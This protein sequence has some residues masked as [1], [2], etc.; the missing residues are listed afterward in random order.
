MRCDALLWSATDAGCCRG[1]ES[2]RARERERV[3][4][5]ER[6]RGSGRVRP[7]EALSSMCCEGTRYP[8]AWL[9]SG[10]GERGDGEIIHMI[11]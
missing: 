1:S 10:R 5:S 6:E 3:R 8:T 2:A 9:S 4:E 7:K 11:I